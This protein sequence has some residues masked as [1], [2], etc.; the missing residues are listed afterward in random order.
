MR[1][2]DNAENHMKLDIY[3][4]KRRDVSKSFRRVGGCVI[5]V[6]KLLVRVETEEWVYEAFEL[7]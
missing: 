5:E 7:S 1:R 3:F 4:I 6:Q 2:A